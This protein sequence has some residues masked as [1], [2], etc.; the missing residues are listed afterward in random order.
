MAQSCEDW[1]YFSDFENANESYV[2]IVLSILRCGLL[3]GF[4][5]FTRCKSHLNPLANYFLPVYHWVLFINFTWAI[6]Q[7]LL[8]VFVYHNYNFSNL[9]WKGVLN[10]TSNGIRFFAWNWFSFLILQRSSGTAAIKRALKYAAI[11]ALFVAIF[12]GV[13]ATFPSSMETPHDTSIILSLTI[14]LTST[15]LYTGILYWM[16]KKRRQRWGITF[17]SYIWLMWCYNFCYNIGEILLILDENY[18]QCFYVA[19]Y[20]IFPLIQPI[21]LFWTLLDDSKYWRSFAIQLFSVSKNSEEFYPGL[22]DNIRRFAKGTTERESYLNMNDFL[23][24]QIPILDLNLFEEDA[25]A[26]GG[27]AIIYA[28]YYKNQRVAIKS[29]LFDEFTQD[30]VFDFF[31]EAFLCQNLVH[32]NIVK[33]YGC[34]LKPPELCLVYEWASHNTLH[35]VLSSDY[36]LTPIDKKVLSYDICQALK[37]MHS[38]FIIHR[39]INTLNILCNLENDRLVAKVCDFGTSRRVRTNAN[40]GLEF[41]TLSNGVEAKEMH[42]TVGLG[43]FPFMSPEIMRNLEVCNTTN[44]VTAVKARSDYNFKVDVFSY[45]IVVWCILTRKT[46]YAELNSLQKIQQTV[47]GESRPQMP[48]PVSKVWEA[49]ITRCWAHD[50]RKRPNFEDIVYFWQHVLTSRN[51]V[52]NSWLELRNETP[53]MVAATI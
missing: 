16:I 32:K 19:A 52:V 37:Y 30:V 48:E 23:S 34:A 41:G 4:I 13:S 38:K 9:A 10:G 43:T 50:P 42:L 18:Y 53:T 1:Y 5:C 14:D 47:L 27:N 24:M 33:F 28:T 29:L 31:N 26:S 46:P 12:M 20:L 45:G 49:M 8:A 11:M 15:L 39:D 44:F 25:V 7:L 51:D 6:L 2:Q 17:Y 21:L 35:H 3:L 40:R 22:F 36:H